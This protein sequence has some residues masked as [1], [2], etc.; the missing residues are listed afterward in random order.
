M[1]I[2]IE[3]EDATIF[4][5]VFNIGAIRIKKDLHGELYA[6]GERFIFEPSDNVPEQLEKIVKEGVPAC[7][8]NI[9]LVLDQLLQRV[10]HGN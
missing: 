2:K 6:K 5:N 10:Q 7:L 9:S 4:I 8:K 1:F 3:D